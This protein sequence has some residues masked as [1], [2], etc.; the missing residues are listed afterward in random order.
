MRKVIQLR[1][2][3]PK[4]HHNLARI[5]QVSKK[6]K[7]A[8]LSQRRAIE[9][10]PNYV[11]AIYG[12]GTILQEL[13][14]LREA[15]N[16]YLR[17]IELNN[18]YAKAYYE[19]SNFKTLS[20]K[21]DWEVRLFSPNFLTNI[22]TKDQVNIYFARANILHK[23]GD[24]KESARNLKLANDTKLKLLPS[25]ADDLIKKSN[26]LIKKSCEHISFNKNNL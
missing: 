8:E 16:C 14:D 5:L 21:T 13:G 7:E 18:F 6:L 12:L 2:K 26:I 20:R 11:E 3:Y 9:F 4:A 15:E 24:Y 25:K 10:N 22:T 1:P 23:K 17:V 19:L